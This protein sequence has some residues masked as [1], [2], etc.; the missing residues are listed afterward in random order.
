MKASDIRKKVDKL[1]KDHKKDVDSIVKNAQK[2]TKQGERYIKDQSEK[3]KT[4]LEIMGLTLQKEKLYYE[5]GRVIA[6]L[7]KKKWSA[8]K[9]AQNISG[10]I[11]SV[12]IQIGKKKKKA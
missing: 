5:L 1:W 8:S 3:G 6:R 2:L 12:N 9:K 10:K 7:P 11:R 4:Q